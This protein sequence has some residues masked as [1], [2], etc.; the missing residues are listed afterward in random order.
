MCISLFSGEDKLLKTF[1]IA[2]IRLVKRFFF[3]ILSCIKPCADTKIPR[4]ILALWKFCLVG[5]MNK[6]TVSYNTM[7]QVF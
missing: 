7:R 2:V 1:E 5:E 4:H 6:L 3:E